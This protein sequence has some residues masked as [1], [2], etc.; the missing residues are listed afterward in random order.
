M[1]TAGRDFS[2]DSWA[3]PSRQ[4]KEKS[5]L[6]WFHAHPTRRSS[7]GRSRTC[8]RDYISHLAKDTQERAA[9]LAFCHHDSYPDKQ[10]KIGGRA[11][12]L[13]QVSSALLTEDC[14]K[15]RLCNK[16]LPFHYSYCKHK[17]NGWQRSVVLCALVN[18]VL[19]VLTKLRETE[20]DK[21]DKEK[22]W[23]R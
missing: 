22:K 12:K 3:Q 21:G 2:Q 7:L 16:L 1:E 14:P 5:H 19:R 6:R 11:D 18:V 8:C 9:C 20:R 15:C 10:H 4:M 13:H 23:E 17:L